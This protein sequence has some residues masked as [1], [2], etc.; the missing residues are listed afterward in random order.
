MDSESSSSRDSVILS[1]ATQLI[2]IHHWML[3][4]PNGTATVGGTC[5]NC[6][7]TKFFRTTVER[8]Y[9]NYNA[10]DWEL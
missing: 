4:S 7:M 5:A 6:G 3:E 1:A 8:D 10:K 9:G 2:C